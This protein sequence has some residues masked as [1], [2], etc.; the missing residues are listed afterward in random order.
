VR[1]AQACGAA[2]A[3]TL[4]AAFTGAGTRVSHVRGVGASVGR[5]AAL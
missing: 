5:V 4:G 3:R 2:G 1:A